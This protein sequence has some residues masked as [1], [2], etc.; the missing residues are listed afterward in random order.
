MREAETLSRALTDYRKLLT[1]SAYAAVDKSI[2]DA[3]V[4]R[5]DATQERLSIDIFYADENHAQLKETA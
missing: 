5:V 2:I 3:E 1:L 4:S